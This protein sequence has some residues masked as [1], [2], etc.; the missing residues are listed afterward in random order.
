VAL[1]SFSNIARIPELKRRVLFTL[2]MLL[3]YRIGVHVP[4]PGINTVKLKDFFQQFQQTLFGI[5]DMF[6]GGAM[7][8]F[9][10]FSLGIMPYISASIIL[11]LLTVVVPHLERLS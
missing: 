8:N 5:V 4:T 6:T 2:F 10:V 1:G 7:E 3:V 11:Q 9:S